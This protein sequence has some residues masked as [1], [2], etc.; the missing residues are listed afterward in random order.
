MQTKIVN[1]LFFLFNYS[2]MLF[3]VILRWNSVSL[4]RFTFLSLVQIFSYEISF[5]CHLKYPYSRFSSLSSFLVIFVLLMFVLFVLFL[6]TVISLPL[7]FLMKSSSHCVKKQRTQTIT[8]YIRRRLLTP[9]LLIL[10]INQY[11][12]LFTS[13]SSKTLSFLE[14]IRGGHLH[15]LTVLPPFSF[16]FCRA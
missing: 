13:G 15:G 2:Q 4:L 3:C 6:I 16:H 1:N 12:R 5:V 10:S 9:V 14:S 8:L 7:H 11:G